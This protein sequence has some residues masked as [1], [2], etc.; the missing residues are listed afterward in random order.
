M[1]IILAKMSLFKQ[2]VLVRRDT[3]RTAGF[4]LSIL[5]I[6]RQPMAL[7]CCS[8]SSVLFNADFY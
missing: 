2:R 3:V 8:R 7:Y 6:D 4:L 1:P 5:H